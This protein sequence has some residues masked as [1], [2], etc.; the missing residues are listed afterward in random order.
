MLLS[1]ILHDSPTAE[2]R[3]VV[4]VA[5]VAPRRDGMHGGAQVIGR[6]LDEIVEAHTIAV[7][8]L[9]AEDEPRMEEELAKNCALVEEV[10]C[11]RRPADVR[12][13]VKL[14][15]ACVRG[16]PMWVDDWNVPAF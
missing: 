15:G 13:Y 14:L 10:R 11:S 6:I 16:V 4:I 3:K 5:P 2:R 8:Y 9:R 1:G 12:R 7:A